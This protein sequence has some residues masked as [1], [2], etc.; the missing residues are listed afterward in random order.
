MPTKLLIALLAALA[1]AP[2]A[3]AAPSSPER[4]WSFTEIRSGQ[5]DSVAE[6][7]IQAGGRLART[8]DFGSA[9]FEY[10]RVPPDNRATGE[11]T[12]TAS[13]KTFDVYAQSASGRARGAVIGGK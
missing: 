12:S 11:I 1:F 4:F 3:S 8:H 6:T 9:A 2:A 10:L 13:G 7:A 5:T